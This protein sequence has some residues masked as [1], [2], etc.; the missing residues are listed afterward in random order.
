MN[1]K[2]A[3][4]AFIPTPLAYLCARELWTSRGIT[5]CEVFIITR[6]KVTAEQIRKLAD[7]DKNVKVFEILTGLN[8]EKG[9]KWTYIESILKARLRL[10]K[11]LKRVKQ[12]DNIIVSQIANPYM[13]LII[14][15]CKYLLSNVIVVD[16]G[17]STLV[18]YDI[19]TKDGALTVDN[20]AQKTNSILTQIEQL[21]FS[22]EEIQ[23][24]QVVYFTFWPL[25]A[26]G[27]KLL[28]RN[29]FQTLINKRKKYK[30]EC[31]VYFIG[32]PWVH[33]GWVNEE[34]YTEY[35]LKI[36]SYYANKKLNFIYFPHRNETPTML[37]G[38]I[39]I[40]R[41]DIPFEL[42]LINKETLPKVV[43]GF[44]STSIATT[45]YLFDGIICCEMHWS[46]K[47][48]KKI[49]KKFP[50]VFNVLKNISKESSSVKI[51]NE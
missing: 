24:K 16:D 49:S 15:R 17:A 14:K 36:A 18:E 8:K 42:Y 43:A 21:I 25:K 30:Q 31:S 12:S 38:K 48:V 4:K 19:L 40:R 13:R 29:N 51:I 22:T 27:P 35:I 44:F 3:Y 5:D 26:N 33:A 1:D 6:N 10:H 39:K 20:E 11:V 2:V 28:P 37:E 9:K 34:T 32:Q 41:P 45:L 7:D 46:N 23:S 47:T 50:I